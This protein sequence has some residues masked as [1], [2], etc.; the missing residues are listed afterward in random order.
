M[1]HSGDSWNY[2]RVI[3]IERHNGAT[4][5]V[6]SGLRRVSGG[7]TV[8]T[9]LM[10]A[11][12]LGALMLAPDLASA[13]VQGYATANVNMRSGP[14]T[15]YPAVTV[16]PVGAPV[17][18][19]GCM[20]S[21]NWCDVSFVG[22]RGWVSGNYVQAS[23]RSNRVY[24]APDYYQGLGIPTVTFEVNDY[25]GR[26]YRGRDFYRERDRWRDYNWRGDR[27]PPPP[28]RWD[29]RRGPPPGGWDRDRDDRRPPPGGWDRD[30]DGHR[31]P[32]GGW[33][34]DRD[35][36]DRGRPDRDRPDRADRDRPDRGRPDMVRPDR[37]RPD[38]GRPDNGRPD[39][40]RPD[41]D[42]PDARPDRGRPDRPD[43]PERPPQA[44][45]GARVPPGSPDAVRRCVPGSCGN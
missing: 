25:W 24:V 8:K 5:Q 3:N 6:W 9:L 32:P 23:Y 45:Q 17:S 7:N 38:A 37:D 44:D 26:Y 16:I 20:S 39:M 35:D 28:P 19:N 40:G 14:S 10:G 12:A 27:Q 29:D 11:A 34:R 22:G 41:R 15:A 30:R 42:R 13:A 1:T 36:R 33:D 18:I 4:G 31:G 43:R 2:R 21:V